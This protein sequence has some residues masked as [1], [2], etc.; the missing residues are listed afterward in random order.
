MI[1]ETKNRSIPINSDTVKFIGRHIKKND[2][3][4]LLQSGSAVEFIITGT[5]AEAILAGDIHCKSDE[6]F[7]PRYC[8]FADGILFADRLLSHKEEKI[9]LF[10]NSEKRE[11]K[12]KIMLVSEAGYGPA[13]IKSI[14]VK[15]DE[16]F[17]I[18][19]VP[20]N[21]LFIEFIGDSITCAYGVEDN[22]DT[23]PF[24]TSSENFTKSYAYLAAEK[25]NADYS[26]VCYSGHG[27][28]SGFSYGEK[29]DQ[30]T[31][32]PLYQF[33]SSL[34]E[35]N[36]PWD[37][38]QRKTDVVYI[39]LGTNDL[40]YVSAEYDSRSKEFIADY[41]NFLKTI[42]KNNPKAFIICTMGIM[43]GGDIIYPLIEKAALQFTSETDD[44]NIICFR[45]PH[46]DLLS[47]GSGADF[48][49]SQTTQKKN[50]IIAAEKICHA[51][52]LEFPV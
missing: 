31:I 38:S 33:S 29:N 14:N 12:I 25:L 19:P 4:W 15:S 28:I 6:D 23:A 13:G 44:K 48:H 17:P 9:I 35:Y 22:T 43:G 51:L 32:P 20:N 50:S 2:I 34:P 10:D 21:K 18:K 52:G 41:L 37:F 7:R 46:Q 8:I 40:H 11:V 27:I 26:T 39:N 16:L 1:T 3:Q 36:A 45:S 5:R 24:R 49:P 42:R 47:E 30:Q